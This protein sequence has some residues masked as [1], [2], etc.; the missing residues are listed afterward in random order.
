MLAGS[1]ALLNAAPSNAAPPGF[2]NFEKRAKNGERLN[3]V[4]FGASLT[5]GANASD[6]QQTSYRALIG[7]RLEAAYPKAH[8]RFWDAAIGGTGSQLGAFRL[9]RDVL[10]HKPDLV[11]L[12]F[13]AN[14]DINSDNPETLASYES[15]VRRLIVEAQVPVV[16]VIFPFQWNVQQGDTTRMKR[17]DAH[18]KIAQAYNTAVGDAIV[19]CIERVKNGS[20]PI[21]QIWPFDGVHPGDKGYAIFADAAWQAYQDAVNNNLVCHAPAQMLYADTYMTQARVRL[22]SLGALPPG[23]HTGMPNPTAAYFDFLMSRWLDDEVIASNRREVIGAN[24]KK[25]KVRQPV[26]RLTAKFRGR[27]LM[28]LGEA[29][30][31]SGK[32]RVYIDGKLAERQENGKTINEFAPGDFANRIK[33]NG[34]HVQVIAE[35]L[36]PDME[37]T[38]EIEPIFATDTEQEL[39]LESIC[40]AGPNA[41]VWR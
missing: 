28:L 38:L 14:D 22:S 25:E 26:E 4:F 1:F 7:Q 29:T 15:L 2:K 16:Q 40:V 23:W 10:R 36:A 35:N 24:G 41:R 32:Y 18:L 9:D 31:Q 33:G 8:F 37:H 12:D 34:H 30:P 20:I 11:F 13:S 21:E 19:L 3:V 17:R 27:M 5:W 6:P 39:R